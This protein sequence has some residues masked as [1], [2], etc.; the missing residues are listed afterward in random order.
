M[1][2][3]IRVLVVD[4]SAFS[5]KVMREVL[6]AQD[7]L[8]VVGAAHDGLDAL[9]KIEALRPDVITLDLV[10]PHLDGLGVLHALRGKLSPRVVVVSSADTRSEQVIAA[11]GEGAVDF[12]HKPTALATDM[13]Y[14]IG[15][16]LARKVKAAAR[17]NVPAEVLPLPLLPESRKRVEHLGP[18]RRVVVIG[19]STGGPQALGRLIPQLSADFPAPVAVVLHIPVGYTRALAQRLDEQSALEVVESEAGSRLLP[20]RVML[21]RAGVHLKLSGKGALC[22]ARQTTSPSDS[23]HRPSVDALFLSAAE[24]WGADVVAVVLTGMGN[25]GTEGARA[26]RAA[27]GRVLIQSEPS[28]IIYGMPRSV[29]E[30]GLASHQAGLEEMPELLLR[31]AQEDLA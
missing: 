19:T 25:D 29:H 28:C 6:Q 5:R 10:M 2:P 13:L 22:V 14:E 7:G 30:A 1:S 26:V 16:E 17:A 18:A 23:P 21:A 24:S 31:W 20:G 15:L 3:A 8:E 12:V 11:L 27:G 4:D 9:E